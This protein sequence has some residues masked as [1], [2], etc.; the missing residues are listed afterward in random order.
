MKIGF[1]L[2][3]A[4]LS[5]VEIV[6]IPS[7]PYNERA[8]IK[9]MYAETGKLGGKKNPLVLQT[10]DFPLGVMA[11]GKTETLKGI[12]MDFY[13][14]NVDIGPDAHTV[15]VY[16]DGRKVDTL[17]HWAPYKIRDLPKGEY[18]VELVLINQH[19]KKVELPF[20]RQKEKIKIE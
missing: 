1:V 4:A 12:L 9:S 7:T 10:V 15:D 3:A 8:I 14:Y 2:C 16:I 5:A 6:K 19:G 17:K 11:Q 18:E 20:G 13:V